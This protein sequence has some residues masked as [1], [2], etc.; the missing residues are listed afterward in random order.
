MIIN[1]Y[2][3][4]TKEMHKDL[5]KHYKNADK[6]ML[7]LMALHWV[8]GTFVFSATYETY[9]F[10]FSAS[11][12]ILGV[13][14]YAF[15]IFRGKSIYRI[16]A[17][18]SLLSFSLIFIQ[19]QFGRIELHFHVFIAL[20]FLMIYK[21]IKPVVVGALFTLIHHSVF[22]ILQ[23]NN[24]TLFGQP[25]M[26]FNYGC[27]YDILMLHA[28]FVLFELS[29]LLYILNN[30]IT[31]FLAFIRAKYEIESINA[32]LENTI[33]QRTK[34]LIEAKEK[35]EESGKLKE[36]FLAN[37]SHEIRTPMNAVLGFTDLLYE[38][39]KEPKHIEYLKSIRSSGK[40]L[41]QIINDILEISK[42]QAGKMNIDL[43]PVNPY[44]LLKDLHSIFKVKIDEKNLEFICDI[45]KNL[46]KSLLLDEV[47]VRQ[48]LFNLLGNAVKFTEKGYIKITATKI[49]RDEDKSILDFIIKIEDSGIGIAKNQQ[50][51]MFEPFTQQDGQSAKLFGGTG[52]GLSISKK[53]ANLM[54]GDITLESEV[55]KGS[56]F[57]V[58]INLVSI[59]STMAEE[60]DMFE[61]EYL[62][63]YKFEHANILLVDDIETNRIL[64]KN[65]LSNYDFEIAEADN[66]ADALRLSTKGFDLILMD[67]KMPI[68]DGYEATQKIKSNPK[69]AN[70]PIFALTA[71]VLHHE[72][73]KEKNSIFDNFLC[74]PIN[75]KI[76]LEAIATVIPHKIAHNDKIS[77]KKIDELVE[78]A[79][80][81]ELDEEG[82][83][84]VKNVLMPKLKESKNS[85][86][87][88]IIYNFVVL[89]K[90]FSHK[91]SI[92]P[93]DKKAEKLQHH[94]EVFDIES[95]LL[96]FE[97]IDVELNSLIP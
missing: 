40:Q 45:D 13:N 37:M 39:I 59:S 87:F 18:I 94:I 30:Q 90:E 83:A 49:Y 29:V 5:D 80:L 88:D 3:N 46:P 28:F 9:L 51:K 14:I 60:A 76:L 16:I 61:Y 10:G 67:I 82:I 74:K 52:L 43:K 50:E 15:K 73:T 24:I 36:E 77:S 6:V 97:S 54:G 4:L 89:L 31:Q 68:M 93:L 85:G 47:R 20:S 38:E 75:K 69:T 62:K 92:P 21:D 41:L 84:F 44:S 42:M 79:D 17:A 19:E 71:S 64:I 72:S 63:S 22:F 70:I 1:A 56:V 58:H 32:N 86:D 57:T 95:M 53:L 48:I 96:I 55:N 81:A 12:L 33:L 66:G 23:N 27:G 34:E 78:N 11:S 8:L 65:Y 91:Y 26:I 35:A 2:R 25:V 7:I